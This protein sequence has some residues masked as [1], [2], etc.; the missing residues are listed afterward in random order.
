MF[1]NFNNGR[2]PDVYLKIQYGAVR[3]GRGSLHGRRLLDLYAY[4]YRGHAFANA[5]TGN[6][7]L[8]GLSA[9]R[10]EWSACAKY[11][12]AIAFYAAG[13]FVAEII[14]NHL[15]NRADTAGVRR[16]SCWRSSV[17]FR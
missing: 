8:F 9:A 1:W 17:R 7:V 15:H 12:L 14:Q 13:I 10:L 6:M 2:S 5:V 16:R 11:L 4:L 3:I